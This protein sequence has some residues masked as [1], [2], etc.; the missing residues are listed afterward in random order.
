MP[1]HE[2]V[3]IPMIMEEE[4][5]QLP[6]RAHPTANPCSR[7]QVDRQDRTMQPKIHTTIHAQT[8]LIE[9]HRRPNRPS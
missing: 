4:E 1:F 8:P 6:T 7:V 9:N 3:T 2:K 5:V